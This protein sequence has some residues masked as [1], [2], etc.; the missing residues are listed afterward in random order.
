MLA[1]SSVTADR[2]VSGCLLQVGP[3]VAGF[4]DRA[5]HR[6][7]S[8]AVDDPGAVD[9]P[10]PGRGATLRQVRLH[11]LLTVGGLHSAHPLDVSH[12]YSCCSEGKL[13]YTAVVLSAPG[14]GNTGAPARFPG[15]PNIVL[16][17]G[18]PPI[19]GCS[20]SSCGVVTADVGWR[21]CG[22]STLAAQRVTPA[23][24]RG[25]C[26]GSRR[27]CGTVRSWSRCSVSAS[28][29]RLFRRVKASAGSRL[30]AALDS[31]RIWPMSGHA[32]MPSQV[33]PIMTRE[34]ALGPAVAGRRGCSAELSIVN[35]IVADSRGGGRRGNLVEPDP[36]LVGQE[37]RRSS[38]RR[39]VRSAAGVWPGFG[40]MGVA[41]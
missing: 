26:S 38:D 40:S 41:G 39:R 12:R 10:E 19:D 6:A 29:C 18:N 3:P 30:P 15:A 13:N 31:V 35:L 20:H 25:P 2:A 21:V 1:V 14:R 37:S 17:G 8:Q 22:H 33:G 24:R 27:L 16:D 36:F 4:F 32:I 9:Q 7:Q 11:D 28:R 34:G 5:S 23:S